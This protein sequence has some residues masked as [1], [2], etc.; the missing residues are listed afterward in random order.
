M[1][2]LF[3]L[4]LLLAFFTNVYA[5][6]TINLP[7]YKEYNAATK[8]W[9]TSWSD[10]KK[11]YGFVPNLTIKKVDSDIFNI[12][13]YY[14]GSS[15]GIIK[16]NVVYDPTKTAEIRK[17]NSNNNLLAYRYTG[18]KD[19]IWTSN[20]TLAEIVANK[21][22]WTSSADAKIY[23]MEASQ[24]SSTVYSAT[25]ASSTT[26]T[27]KNFPI[28]FLAKKTK[29]KG[30]WGDWSNWSPAPSKS[31]FELKVITEGKVYSFKY[32]QDGKL[33][34]NYTITYNN[35]HT[36]KNRVHDPKV[37]CYKINE[38]TDDW[39]Y[40][41]N[42]TIGNLFKNPEK[43]SDENSAVISILDDEKTGYFLRIK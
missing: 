8:K 34:K 39:I 1:K 28:S 16:S 14:G 37:N 27:A 35:E 30:T 12:E 4:C 11:E 9:A 7:Y 33:I 40:L 19:Y 41:H 36:Q 13:I 25:N 3:S 18:S 20:I 6:A 21:S 29:I 26:Q 2:K 31:Y 5:Q 38:S 10:S 43:W 23:L 42:T 15:S 17:S 22:K 32:Y 24:G